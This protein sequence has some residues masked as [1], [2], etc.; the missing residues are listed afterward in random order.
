MAISYQGAFEK[1]ERSRDHHI[2]DQKGKHP[3]TKHSAKVK[4]GEAGHN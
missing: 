2:P 3:I 4:R 1:N